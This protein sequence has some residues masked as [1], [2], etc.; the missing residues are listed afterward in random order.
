MKIRIALFVL[1]VAAMAVFGLFTQ[2]D[3]QVIYSLPTPNWIGSD[4]SISKGLPLVQTPQGQN[5]PSWYAGPVVGTVYTGPPKTGLTV[6]PGGNATA[7]VWYKYESGPDPT[8]AFCVDRFTVEMPT[9]Q[10]LQLDGK[11]GV[12][13]EIW[14]GI[15]G[16]GLV[17]ARGGGFFLSITF[18]TPIGTDANPHI[19]PAPN[20]VFALGPGQLTACSASPCPPPK[21]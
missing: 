2:A 13:E 6:F 16:Y 4:P 17:P 7:W 12:P 9:H 20:Q 5:V 14:P 18:D 8:I 15:K 21:R 1:I 11:L 19:Q 10:C 3:A